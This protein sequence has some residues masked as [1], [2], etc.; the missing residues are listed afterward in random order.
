MARELL[1]VV[2]QANDENCSIVDEEIEEVSIIIDV[3]K[4]NFWE[5]SY[6]GIIR[7][8]V[9]VNLSLTRIPSS[10]AMT[11]SRTLEMHP[12]SPLTRK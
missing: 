6:Y 1:D 2:P 7:G 11:L 9:F 12:S 10:K 8:A 3:T 5:V 4:S